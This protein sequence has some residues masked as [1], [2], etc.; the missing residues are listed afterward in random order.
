[1]KSVPVPVWCMARIDRMVQ[2]GIMVDTFYHTD[3]VVIVVCCKL[4]PCYIYIDWIVIRLFQIKVY[5]LTLTKLDNK[6]HPKSCHHL[7]DIKRGWEL[8]KKMKKRV[9]FWFKVHSL[10]L[11]HS[12]ATFIHISDNKWLTWVHCKV[13]LRCNVLY[14]HL[15][16]VTHVFM[17]IFLERNYNQMK[18]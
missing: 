9:K 3:M 8:Q 1:M 11:A 7:N 5:I 14:V 16:S 4:H 15:W 17:N 2:T 6:D 18:V 12:L 10:K 13:Y